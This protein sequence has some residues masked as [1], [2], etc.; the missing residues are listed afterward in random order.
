MSGRSFWNFNYEK[1]LVDILLEHNHQKFKSQNGWS[2]EGW[3]S[4]VKMFTEK[5]PDAGFSKSQIQD[6]EKEL[7]GNYKAIRDGKKKSGAG[8]N[9]SL[10]MII[11]EPEMWVKLIKEIPKLKKFQV[12]SF[13][14]YYKLEQLH[15]DILAFY[16][17]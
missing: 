10:C 6:K 13:P 8:W 4:I 16:F 12:K 7:K 11:A 14:L 5:F 1:G 9:D 3:R 15:D 17:F 2:P